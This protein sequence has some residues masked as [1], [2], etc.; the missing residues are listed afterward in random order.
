[1]KTNNASAKVSLVETPQF[2][3]E[4]A[5]SRT[6]G[7][8]T[9]AELEVLKNKTVA[10]AGLG[11]VGGANILTLARLGVGG[12][13]I[14][15]MDT[16]GVE[17]FNRQAGANMGTVGRSKID[18]MEEM[19]LAIN[20]EIRIKKFPKGVHSHNMAEF[21]AGVDAYVDS[22]DF[23]VFKVRGEV[24]DYCYKHNIP[25]TTVGPIGMGAALVNFLPGKMSFHEYFQWKESDGDLEL[26]VK[27]LLGL[28]P[29]VPHVSY[30]VDSSAVDLQN[31]K[32][33][34][35]P[36]ACQ[37][38]S[39]VMG[40]EI[41]KILLNRG[42]V[43]N[44]PHSIVFDAYKNRVFHTHLWGGNKNPWQKLKIALVKRKLAKTLAAGKKAA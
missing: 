4:V 13:H 23:F 11:G 14:A 17:N 34:S 40:V 7:L 19:A 27:F 44:A 12:F 36:M 21:F 33:P 43:L 35:T 37:I 8:I 22:L 28:T 10:V 1:M 24:F 41:M 30:I 26:G 3:R 9:K 38:C 6:I 2:S 15:D 32:G 31:R 25:A 5:F 16:F 18:V 29:K 20:P 39:G 42:E